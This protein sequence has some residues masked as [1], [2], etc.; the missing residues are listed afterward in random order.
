ML[1]YDASPSLGS[2]RCV[3]HLDVRHLSGATNHL[4]M[5]LEYLLCA[6]H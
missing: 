3:E 2:S 5:F 1:G 4:E 6:R